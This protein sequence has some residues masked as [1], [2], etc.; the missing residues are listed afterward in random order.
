MLDSVDDHIIFVL[1][2][3]RWILSMTDDAERVDI[4]VGP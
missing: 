3:G 2:A 4:A 1:P